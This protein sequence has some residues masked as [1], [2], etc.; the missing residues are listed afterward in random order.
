MLIYDGDCGFCTTVV[1][2]VEARLRL[3]P[4]RWGFLPAWYKTPTDGPVIINARSETVAEKPAFR[5]AIRSRRCLVPASGFYEWTAGE[6][7]KRLPWYITRADGAPMAFAGVWQ[8]WEREGQ[9]LTT[10]AIVSTAAS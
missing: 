9:R 7:G 5:N 4:M 8:E 2:W 1:R 10:C 6:G 3:R